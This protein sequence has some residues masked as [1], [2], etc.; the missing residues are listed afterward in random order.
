M[1]FNSIGLYKNER[2]VKR[3]T[4]CG[5]YAVIVGNYNDDK[6]L[7]YAI[8]SGQRSKGYKTFGRCKNLILNKGYHDYLSERDIVEINKKIFYYKD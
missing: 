5:K 4:D 7:F 8:I 1:F 2:I 6:P 3:F